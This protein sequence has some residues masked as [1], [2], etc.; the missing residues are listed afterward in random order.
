MYALPG[1]NKYLK[2]FAADEIATLQGTSNDGFIFDHIKSGTESSLVIDGGYPV[3]VDMDEDFM[4]I[5]A[6]DNDKDKVLVYARENRTL[7]AELTPSDG[8][9]PEELD[10]QKNWIGFGA[11]VAISGGTVVVGAI[12][13]S[14]DPESCAEMPNTRI[15]AAYVFNLSSTT[16]IRTEDQKLLPGPDHCAYAIINICLLYTSPSPRDQR[17]SRMP[18]SA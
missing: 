11:S 6:R 8:D 4:V 10:H 9:G 5:A 12:D 16:G 7:I 13:W 14:I 1:K 17:G 2:N 15:G 3:R 18:S